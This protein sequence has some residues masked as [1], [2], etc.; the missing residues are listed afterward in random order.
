M[1]YFQHLKSKWDIESNW[2]VFIILLVFSIT[3]FSAVFARKLVFSLL[4]IAESD[5]FWLKTLVWLL[6]IMP[7][8][9]IFLLT[10]GAIFG[11]FQFFWGFFKKMM[12]RFVPGS[13]N[14]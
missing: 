7:L 4:G 8:Y 13:S 12:R 2:Q 6:T 10:Y 9:N 11:Q 14:S 3:G 5:P 1:K